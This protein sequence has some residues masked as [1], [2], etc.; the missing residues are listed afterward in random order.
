MK[1]FLGQ[2]A[3]RRLP[4]YTKI[5]A[6]GPVRGITRSVADGHIAPSR[7]KRSKACQNHCGSYCSWS[8]S[9]GSNVLEIQRVVEREEFIVDV[10]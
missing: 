2:L 6:K 10:L 5:I 9:L 4:L 8:T 3:L 1:G 7:W